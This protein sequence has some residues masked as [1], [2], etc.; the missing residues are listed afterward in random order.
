MQRKHEE[1]LYD[2]D[3][4]CRKSEVGWTVNKREKILQIY[5]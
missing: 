5:I 1:F 3:M 4:N 2:S